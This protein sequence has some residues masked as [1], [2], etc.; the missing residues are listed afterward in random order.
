MLPLPCI[1]LWYNWQT[2]VAL[3]QMAKSAALC[4]TRNNEGEG[5]GGQ[6]IFNTAENRGCHGCWMK[7]ECS[8]LAIDKSGELS[9]PFD[10][11]MLVLCLFGLSVGSWE[12]KWTEPRQSFQFYL[13]RAILGTLQLVISPHDVTCEPS[14]SVLYWSVCEGAANKQPPKI[15]CKERQL[16]ASDSVRVYI[17]EKY[18]CSRLLTSHSFLHVK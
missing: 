17:S 10:V 13:P 18:K 3:C 16:Y 2:D 7:A 4:C 15:Q 11:W 14:I 5:G 6:P 9:L 8:E 12:F 1:Y